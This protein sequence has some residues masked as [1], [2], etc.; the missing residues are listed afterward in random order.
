MTAIQQGSKEKYDNLPE[1][2]IL[3]LFCLSILLNN[4]QYCMLRGAF[5]CFIVGEAGH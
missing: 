2:L 5:A 3:W 1:G 4:A